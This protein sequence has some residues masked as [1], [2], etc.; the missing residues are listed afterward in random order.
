MKKISK[1]IMIL[2]SF[3]MLISITNL[4]YAEPTIENIKVDPAEP[5]PLSTV[6][7]KCDVTA[8]EEIQGVKAIFEECKQGFC[9]TG[10]EKILTNDSGNSYSGS[11][12]LTHDDATTLKYH[13]EVKTDDVWTKSET[14]QIDL[15][16]SSNDNN[17]NGDNSNNTPGFTIIFFIAALF[18]VLAIF[19]KKR[20]R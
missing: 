14:T 11:Y 1:Q 17:N 6:D 9:Y 2:L 10:E 8:D 5:E 15:K 20:F 13:V 18:I 19:S 3:M 16:T 7:I 4:V 12:T